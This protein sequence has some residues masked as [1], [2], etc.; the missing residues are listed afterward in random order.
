[1]WKCE[2]EML[3]AQLLQQQKNTT[4]SFFGVSVTVRTQQILLSAKLNNQMH[5]CRSCFAYMYDFHHPPDNII[6]I[7]ECRKYFNIFEFT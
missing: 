6:I 1:M 5:F 2:Y 4:I 7:I 3:L